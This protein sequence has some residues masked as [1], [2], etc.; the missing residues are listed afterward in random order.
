[1]SKSYSFGMCP[2]E[3]ITAAV[4]AQCPDGYPMVIKD[5]ET[6]TAIVEAWNQGIDSHLEAISERSIADSSTGRVNIHCDELHTFLRRLYE[7]GSDD[8]W[9]LRSDILSTLEIEEI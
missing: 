7:N 2:S 3:V 8:A 5:Q 9:L 1:M 4:K 6:W